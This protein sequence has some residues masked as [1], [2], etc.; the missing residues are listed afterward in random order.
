MPPPSSIFKKEGV[1]NIDLSKAPA[2]NNPGEVPAPKGV[3]GAGTG[4]AILKKDPTVNISNFNS[5]NISSK[6][7]DDLIRA[8]SPIIEKEIT[9]IPSVMYSVPTVNI[10]ATNPL[11]V[12]PP[13]INMEPFINS[14]N[15]SPP[16]NT[17]TVTSSSVSNSYVVGSE[18]VASPP[19]KST[20]PYV[21]NSSIN[22]TKAPSSNNPG[23]TSGPQS[24]EN[25]WTTAIDN[26]K[27]DLLF[28][29]LPSNS[30]N[31]NVNNGSTSEGQ[32][33]IDPVLHLASMLGIKV[34]Y[35]FDNRKQ[36]RFTFANN[37]NNISGK[38]GKDV[39]IWSSPSSFMGA[40]IVGDSLDIS[41]E[42]KSSD[43]LVVD[44]TLDDTPRKTKK[45]GVIG[46]NKNNIRNPPPTTSN[47]N[48]S[49]SSAPVNNV[50]VNNAHK[51]FKK[52]E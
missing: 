42:E 47:T 40:G 17:N 29:A 49:V 4:V 10:N 32:P 16:L 48:P 30:N 46:N 19:P 2:L 39:Y 1:R 11:T 13:G 33:L 37:L 21:T 3:W 8:T 7:D 31:N 20:T 14:K 51:K 26:S 22:N 44:D 52:I 45:S 25:I 27:I 36:S 12:A 15:I 5:V 9:T 41:N 38:N 6:E 50:K 28:L 18:K 23:T 35:H 43:G 34:N 24:A